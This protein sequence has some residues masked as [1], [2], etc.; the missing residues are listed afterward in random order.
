VVRTAPSSYGRGKIRREYRSS[1]RLNIEDVRIKRQEGI[2]HCYQ[3]YPH[4]QSPSSPISI[5]FRQFLC[6]PN[7]ISVDEIIQFHLAYV[8]IWWLFLAISAFPHYSASLH[9]TL[10]TDGQA[11]TSICLMARSMGLTPL[12]YCT[13]VSEKC[14]RHYDGQEISGRG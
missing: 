2:S 1:T 3:I 4:E 13:P 5:F 12:C 9:Y 14:L 10:D 11:T 6:H 8:I 7:F